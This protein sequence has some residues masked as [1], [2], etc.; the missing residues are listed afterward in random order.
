MPFFKYGMVAEVVYCSAN[1]VHL[2]QLVANG[3]YG[4]VVGRVVEQ[5]HHV[6]H[7]V[8]F[9]RQCGGVGN[10]SLM[11]HAA[12]AGGAHKLAVVNDILQSGIGGYSVL[13]G[14][15]EMFN[16]LRFKMFREEGEIIAFIL[17]CC[18]TLRRIRVSLTHR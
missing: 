18:K 1:V 13:N 8:V 5:S 15:L 7:V 11:H 9:L 2:H 16:V 6:S 4:A 14:H 12:P 10:E 3:G 17:C